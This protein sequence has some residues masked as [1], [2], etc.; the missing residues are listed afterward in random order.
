M[1]PRLTETGSF[2]FR[3]EAEWT[4]LLPIILPDWKKSDERIRVIRNDQ[5]LQ[6][7]E[8]TNAAMEAA[9]GDFIVFADHDDEMTPDALFQCVKALNENPE[10]EVLYSD[11]DKMSMDGHKFSSLISNRTS[12]SI[13]C[14]Q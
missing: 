9:T 12:I 7:A 3:M 13:F 10:I 14:V 2:V 6:I 1:R 11:E 5:A 4:L 8:N